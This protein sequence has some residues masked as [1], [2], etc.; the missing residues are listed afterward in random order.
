M[1]IT[2][3]IKVDN[4]ILS[5][6]ENNQRMSVLDCTLTDV[7]CSLVGYGMSEG[8][9]DENN[10]PIYR[11]IRPSQLLKEYKNVNNEVYQ[12]ISSQW[13]GLLV[14][15][16]QTGS[17]D[18][19]CLYL[20]NDYISWL[21]NHD[22][23][24]YI[25]VGEKLANQGGI[26]EID[27]Q[28]LYEGVFPAIK[29]RIRQVLSEGSSIDTV[30]FSSSEIDKDSYLVKNEICSLLSNQTIMSY[31]EWKER[32]LVFTVKG[33]SFNMIKVDGGALE[34]DGKT[35]DLQSYYI[36]ETQVTQALWKAVMG[37][38]PSYF[39]GDMLPV[40]CIYYYGCTEFFDKLNLIT[41][42][43]F[44]LPT[45]AEWEYAA[46]GGV[47]G[48]GFR[49]A[50]SNNIDEVAWYKDN[51]NDRTHEV[52]NKRPNEL[53]LFDMTGNVSE[54][55]SDKYATHLN[56][57]RGGNFREYSFHCLFN[58]WSLAEDFERYINRGLRLALSVGTENKNDNNS[59]SY[60]ETENYNSNEEDTDYIPTS[61]DR[62]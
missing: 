51:S 41:K 48:K 12:Q 8:L 58:S 15:F 52:G 40:E 55:C 27:S 21:L 13:K 47:K 37:H 38:N 34:V 45:Q 36:G 59:N 54:I 10:K 5:D 23:I 32:F 22:N 42:A 49:Y 20:P 60:G 50:G 1:G 24:H 3:F 9:V 7:F 44:R 18:K 30:V 29:Q 26:V 56:V 62:I 19:S 17:C 61:I 31:K 35:T 11:I 43:H 39:K 33:I 16:L 57:A 46:R 53:G 25:S 4:T 28:D 6:F 2:L 14:K